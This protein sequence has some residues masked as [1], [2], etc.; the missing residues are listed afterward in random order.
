MA[1]EDD[2]MN[3]AA[4]ARLLDEMD[5]ITSRLGQA[6]SDDRMAE[7][8]EIVRDMVHARGD[9]EGRPGLAYELVC[10]GTVELMGTPVERDVS[11]RDA[12]PCPRSRFRARRR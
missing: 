6:V 12:H 10:W 7:L 9:L 11:D 1:P 2:F 8:T 5:A 3:S 4:A